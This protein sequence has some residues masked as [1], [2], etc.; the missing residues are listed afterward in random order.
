MLDHQARKD[1]TYDET[2]EVFGEIQRLAP[3]IDATR[4]VATAAILY[5][6]EIG[7]A[8]NQVVATRLRGML[9]SVDISDQGRVLRWY[10]ALYKDKVSVDIID[11]LNDLSG[12]AVVMVPNLYLINEAI[13][14]HL[15]SF[16]RQGGWLLVGPKAALKN[17]HSVFLTDVPPGAGLAA[18]FG[19]TV[20]RAAYRMG[21]GVLPDM[22]VTMQSGAPF[23]ARMRFANEGLFDELELAGATGIACYANGETAISVN[24]YGDGLAMYVGCEPEEAF[25]RQLVGWLIS[26]GKVTPPLST[27]AD[28][29]VT[30]RSGGGH[31]LIFVL[32]H[33][34]A[35]EEVVLDGKYRE[36]ISDTVVTGLQVIEGQGVRILERIKR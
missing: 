5:S 33:N 35:P 15:E 8:W 24:R 18:V 7:W 11:P 32:N 26:Q 4:F 20:K 12:Y 34:Q 29:E 17:W 22:S 3:I 16:V 2:S 36:L 10:Q 1:S 31:D 19:A 23:A 21:F 14:S 9:N 13:A 25:Y 28:V 30:L 27:D 6:D